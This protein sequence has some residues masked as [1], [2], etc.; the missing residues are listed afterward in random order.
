MTDQTEETVDAPEAE[1]E[2][3]ETTEP[4]QVDAQAETETEAVEETVVTF[5]DDEAPEQQDAPD[6]V[7]NVRKENREL[8]KQLK[9]LKKQAAAGKADE[10]TDLGPEPTLEGSDYDADKY[11]DAL[12]VW[13][14]AKAKQD[15]KAREAKEAQEKQGQAYNA[16][17]SEYQEGKGAFDADQFDEAEDAVKGALSENQ[18]SILIH[19]F[20][21]KA[22]PLIQGLGQ[23]EK[24][25]KE[26][27]TI[28]D[29]IAFAVAATRLETAMKVS[30]RRPKTVPETRTGGNIASG[31]SSDKTLEKLRAEAA[32]TN[33]MSKVLAYKRKLKAG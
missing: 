1:I 32:Q 4:E 16:R 14:Q 17:L 5:G 28:T 7:K 27:G 22:A 2:A 15:A 29:P 3:V 6:W 9:D 23:D 10:K 24:R 21:G 25:L 18:Q 33:D 26:L 11:R 12:R 30:Q 31:A 19:A 20:G 8:N 13:D